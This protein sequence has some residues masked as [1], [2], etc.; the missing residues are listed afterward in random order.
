MTRINR[1]VS[2]EELLKQYSLASLEAAAT[3]RGIEP[4]GKTKA[5]QIQLLARTLYD[6]DTIAS[7]LA[8]LTPSER[9]LLDRV[10]LL[11]GEVLT[12]S[13]RHQ[14]GSEGAI[15]SPDLDRMN[16]GAATTRPKGRFEDI[17]ARRS[18][19]GLLFSVDVGPY[20]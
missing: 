10:V 19:R 8:E 13:L 18:M 16:G 3:A 7:L 6:A 5:K 1:Q 14:L 4:D 20:S 17:V 11:G 9:D 2:A 12:A 15:D